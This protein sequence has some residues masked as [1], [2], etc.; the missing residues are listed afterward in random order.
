MVV[1]NSKAIKFAKM[2]WR[3]QQDILAPARRV[4]IDLRDL[5][6][7]SMSLQKLNDGRADCSD[8]NLAIT[9][10]CKGAFELTKNLSLE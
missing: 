3:S 5:D 10:V 9:Y 6:C 7:Q 2:V 4:S 1:R 8:G